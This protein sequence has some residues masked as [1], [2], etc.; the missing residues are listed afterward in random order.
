MK[1]FLC[2]YIFL[3]NYLPH[4]L[5]LHGCHADKTTIKSKGCLR[6]VIVHGP[7]WEKPQLI[8]P[9][10]YFF[11]EHPPDCHN[12]ISS[13][14]IASRSSKC[15]SR[16][17]FF[18]E[19]QYAN[20]MVIVRY[21]LVQDECRDVTISL[22]DEEGVV[23]VEKQFGG[24]I[25][26]ENCNCPSATWYS[27]MQCDSN[28]EAF[29][30]IEDDL[31]PFKQTK[32]NFSQHLSDMVGRFAAYTRSYSFCHYQI[33]DNKIFKR[34]Y[35]EYVGFAQFL[36]EFLVSLINKV[37]LPDTEFIANL[38]D[39]P[40]SSRDKELPAI[41]IFSWCGSEDTHDIVLPT[42]EMTESV[43]NMQGRVTVDILSVF[44]KQSI[45]FDKKQNKMFWRGRD[46]NKA[47][48]ALVELSKSNFDQV[49]AAF[50]N[51]FFFRDQ[52]DKYGP[53]VPHTNFFSFFNYKF[54]LNLDGTVAAY[55]FPNLLA[56]SSLVFKQDSPYYEFFYRMIKPSVHYI[57]VKQDLS[58][59]LETVHN[60]TAT[61]P[62]GSKNIADQQKHVIG[63]ARKFSLD[64]L[65]PSNIYCYYYKVIESYTRLL[66][67]PILLAD[68]MEQ[69][70]PKATSSCKLVRDEL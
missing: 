19:T 4:L 52:I 7:G 55:R 43:L 6:D 1:H 5:N 48:L 10:R 34:C 27:D 49:D 8:F 21:R 41:P 61:G 68:E 31:S 22:H 70:L 14:R 37:H 45:P 13:A 15:L 29:T 39:W 44:G 2:S 63:N 26:N 47:R 62:I 3:F 51:F 64:N 23:V 25:Y 57:P 54:Q 67:E 53:T 33:I 46:S 59:L 17:Q 30:Q 36:D 40:L 38:G 9:S 66:V 24:T 28:S 50:T 58:N 18:N 20:D 65:M 16:I 11:V 60:H 32:V 12:R 69:V 35:G 56:G 42:Y